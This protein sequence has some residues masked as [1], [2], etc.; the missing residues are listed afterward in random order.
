MARCALNSSGG[1]AV[2]PGEYGILRI[3]VPW[4]SLVAYRLTFTPK[5]AFPAN[6]A[7]LLKNRL[8]HKENRLPHTEKG[9]VASRPYLRSSWVERTAPSIGQEDI[10]VLIVV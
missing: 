3:L 10:L 8:A 1:H 2:R 5:N 4:L 9:C 7:W 6:S